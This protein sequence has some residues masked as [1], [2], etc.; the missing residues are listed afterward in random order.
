MVLVAVLWS[1]F[2][3]EISLQIFKCSGL[4]VLLEISEMTPSNLEID[5]L[6]S[7]KA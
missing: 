5:K 7:R 3:N 4:L 6:P 1:V 2:S